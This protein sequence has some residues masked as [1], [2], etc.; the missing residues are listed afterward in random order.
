MNSPDIAARIQSPAGRVR[1]LVDSDQTPGA[2]IDELFLAT[3]S[4]WPSADEQGLL[5]AEFAGRD[6]REAAED[7]LWALLN[8]RE[9]LYN[10]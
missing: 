5:L 6:R 1:A 2:I 9:F 10:H 7:A 8:T 4:R 3:L